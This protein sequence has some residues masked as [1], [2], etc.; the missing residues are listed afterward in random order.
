MRA[1]YVCNGWRKSNGYPEL[2]LERVYELAAWMI[3][4]LAGDELKEKALRMLWYGYVAE[5]LGDL[6]S[7]ME[8]LDFDTRT[9]LA[10]ARIALEKALDKKKSPQYG[11]ADSLM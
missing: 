6:S 4:V 9:S 8:H 7:H 3:D 11:Y 2:D 1:G 5:T 10:L